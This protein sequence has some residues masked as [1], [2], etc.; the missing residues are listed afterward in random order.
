MMQA[1]N[2]TE[3]AYL[4]QEATAQTLSVRSVLLFVL[5]IGVVPCLLS[6]LFATTHEIQV[7][8]I[9]IG[10]IALL[11]TL[12]NPYWGLIIFVGLLYTRPE[13]VLEPLKGMH[14]SLIAS[15]VTLIGATIQ[16]LMDKEP[17]VKTPLNGMILGFGLIVVLSTLGQDNTNEAAQDIGKL[18]IL[19][20]LVLN[21]VRTPKKY[22]AFVS[23][24]LVFTCYLA[25]YSI[26]KFFQG[27]GIQDH[28][29]LRSQGTGIFGDP[30]DL[31]ATILAGLALTLVRVKQSRQAGRAFYIVLALVDIWG[32][33]LT[34]SRGGLL[35]LLVVLGLAL[36]LF[37]RVKGVALVLAVVL[38]VGFMKFGPSRLSELNSNEESANSR[39]WFWANG[40]DQLMEHPITGVGYDQ[41]P[42]VNGGMTAHN[43]FVFVLCRTRIYRLFLLAGVFILLFSANRTE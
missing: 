17:A 43:S 18:V 39:L 32:V 1:N 9:V 42:D 24:I 10:I 25:I 37:T 4:P 34:N 33:L 41:F 5:G 35:A 3:P 27:D 2:A 15:V 31:A 12:A 40:V 38:G 20:L 8:A 7:I 13:E 16:H 30:N 22:Q 19:V 26:I 23:S 29:V 28:D 11:L 21:L 6:Y 36:L 14:F